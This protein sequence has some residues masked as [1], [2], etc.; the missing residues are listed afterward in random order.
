MSDMD[1]QRYEQEIFAGNSDNYETAVLGSFAAGQ[2][3]YSKTINELQSAAYLLGWSACVY[4]GNNA[5]FMEEM[6]ALFYIITYQLAY[7]MQKGI[8]EY[9]SSEMY[10]TGNFCQVSGIIYRSLQNNN[11]GN[12]PASSPEYWQQCNFM[13][14]A[15]DAEASAGILENKAVNPKQLAA[16]LSLK[17]N[18]ITASNML[19]ADLVD[20]TSST[21]KFASAA[22]LMQIS[23]NASDIQTNTSDIAGL[24]TQIDALSAASDVTDIVGTY[25]ELQAYDTSNLQNNDIVKVLQDNTHDNETTYYRWVVTSGAGTWVLIG[26]EG[27]YYTIAAADAQFVPQ[28][29]TVNG[30]ALSSNIII[31]ASDITDGTLPAGVLPASGVTAGSYTNPLI[32]VDA[33]G[34]ITSAENGSISAALWGTITGALSNQ[35]DLQNA[36]NAKAPLYKPVVYLDTHGGTINPADNT[37]YYNTSP[38]NQSTTIVLPNVSD[39]TIEHKIEIITVINEGTSI[40]FGLTGS[41]F[42]INQTAPEISGNSVVYDIIYQYVSTSISGWV[43]GVIKIGAAS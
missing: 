34:R 21:H 25:A 29:R 17:Q 26:E 12:A 2:A 6:N 14:M 30:K 38:L 10:Y 22:Q 7:L 32:T 15:T 42:W 18:L 39:Y 27:P 40:D 37:V 11:Q 36:L 13:D 16:G 20:D 41:A 3:V 43:C 31:T 33:S 8:P 35:T 9:I 19:D 5:P 24:Q 1:L 28:E 4:G 23:T